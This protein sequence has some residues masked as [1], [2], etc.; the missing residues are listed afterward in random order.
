[1]TESTYESDSPEATEA[2]GT[3]IARS[4]EPG[5]C[6]ALY[7]DLG[8]GK[9]AFTRGLAEGL[10]CDARMVS[11]PTYVIVQEYPGTTPLFHLD[12]YRLTAGEAEFADLGVDEM[13]EDGVVVIEWPARAQ[14][15]LPPKRLDITIEILTP[16]TRSITVN[17]L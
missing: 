5:D 11:S 2:I 16:E 9:T 4:L 13:L 10:G 15:A 6:V 3:K 14:A 1:M 12:L 8:A 17:K 7:G